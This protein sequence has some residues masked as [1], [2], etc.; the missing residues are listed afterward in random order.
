M[1]NIA[2]AITFVSVF[3]VLCV[4]VFPAAAV[5]L[6][7][8][9]QNQGAPPKQGS[10]EAID[11]ESL[12]IAKGT[13]LTALGVYLMGIVNIF[14]ALIGVVAV[15]FIIYAGVQLLTSSGD[16]KKAET[17]KHTIIYAVIGLAIVGLAAALVNW[18][19]AGI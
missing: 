19:I 12:G 2:K 9:D 3:I 6:I 5:S 8:A 4:G 11:G 1:S 15:I 10:I 14:L 16:E 17:A 7:A 13:D 18:V